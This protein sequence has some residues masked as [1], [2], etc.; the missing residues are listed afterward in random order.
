MMTWATGL[1]CGRL[2]LIPLFIYLFKPETQVWAFWVFF[3][4]AW[5]DFLD[6]F[7]AKNFKQET[8]LGKFLDPLADKVLVLSAFVML[9]DQA[10][11]TAPWVLVVLAREL[12]VTGFRLI[13]VERKQNL[14]EVSMLGKI[15]TVLQMVSVGF[16]MLEWPHALLVFYISV[17]VALISMGDY[18]IRNWSVLKE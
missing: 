6:G 1:T 15:K 18:L 17:A 8:V 4:L 3:V 12:I 14:V 13:A 10:Y 11:L 16:L 9:L 5:T 2:F 7:I